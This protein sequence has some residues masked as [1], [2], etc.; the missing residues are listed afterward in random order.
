MFTKVKLQNFRSFGELEFDLSIKNGAPKNLAMVFGENG[1]G[2]SNLMSAFVLLCELW[3]TMK[4]RDMYEEL[5]NHKAFFADEDIESMIRKQIKSDMRDMEAIVNDYRMV[6]NSNPIFAEY[7]FAIDG[8]VGKYC[9]KLQDDEIIYE[10]LEF[11]LNK[12]KGVY[13]ECSR[14]GLFINSGIVKSKEFYNDIKESAKRF[15]G[16]HSL[17]AIIYHELIDKSKAYGVDNISDN[18][19]S[20]LGMVG[21]LSCYLKTGAK[22]LEKLVS[23]LTILANA[24]KGTLP[25]SR[26]IELDLAE[27]IFSKFFSSINSDIRKVYYTRNY[28]DKFINYELMFEKIVAGEYRH[29]EFSRESTGNHQVLK[30]ICYLLEAALGGT[31]II[32]EADSGVHDYLFQ[33]LFEEIRPYIK[34]Q[35]VMTTHNTLL[36]EADFA[37]DST[38]ILCESEE[39]YKEIKSISDYDR[40]TYFKNNIRKKYLD[41]EYG[42]LPN[43]IKT[44]FSSIIQD[45]ENYINVI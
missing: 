40:R 19:N 39:G 12:R 26:E 43:V 3:S 21:T 17:F 31:V 2:K 41:G 45:I 14:E 9:V 1:A 7:E 38:Y 35:V 16:K 42:G 30:V 22:K 6:G 28:N 27:N 25:V 32:D 24:D 5:L 4:V 18:F 23:N 13:F 34:G 15:W 37:R 29:I 36:M 20:V 10:K 44:D 33:K 11:L 8:S